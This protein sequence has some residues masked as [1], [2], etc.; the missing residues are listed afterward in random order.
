MNDRNMQDQAELMVQGQHQLARALT[1]LLD[2]F[3]AWL[4][5]AMSKVP[6]SE[7]HQP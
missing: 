1:D 2:R 7:P 5:K 3:G 4:E 6:P